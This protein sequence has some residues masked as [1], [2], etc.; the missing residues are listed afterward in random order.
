MTWNSPS[1]AVLFPAILT[2][3]ADHAENAQKPKK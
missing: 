3:T 1:A 2:E